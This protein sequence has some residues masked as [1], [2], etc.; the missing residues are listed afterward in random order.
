MIPVTDE[1]TEEQRFGAK[2]KVTAIECTAGIRPPTLTDSKAYA[3]FTGPRRLPGGRPAFGNTG[4]PDL[5]C[6]VA[7]DILLT[8]L[9]FNL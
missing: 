4:N 8:P 1:E 2:P 5:T 9:S 6:L 7:R 3:L